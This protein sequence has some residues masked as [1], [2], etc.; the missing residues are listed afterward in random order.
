MVC[1]FSLP[2]TSTSVY[3]SVPLVLGHFQVGNLDSP[4]DGAERS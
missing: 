2:C 4:Q 3:S 1:G